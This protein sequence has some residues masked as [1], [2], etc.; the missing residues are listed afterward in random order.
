MKG[1]TAEDPLSGKRY[2]RPTK[3]GSIEGG[4]GGSEVLADEGY[5]RPTKGGSIEGHEA[6]FLGRLEQVTSALQ[7]AAPLKDNP[8]PDKIPNKTLHPPYKGRLH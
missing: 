2:I 6:T 3:G 4:V 8:R 7:R 1:V 5:I